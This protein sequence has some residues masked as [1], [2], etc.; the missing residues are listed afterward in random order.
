MTVGESEDVAWRATG[1]DTG[2]RRKCK[3]RLPWTFHC[4]VSDW[5]RWSPPRCPPSGISVCR[6]AQRW[7]LE[8]GRGKGGRVGLPGRVLR[9]RPQ[10]S[11][12]PSPTVSLKSGE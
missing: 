9:I 3:L 8:S 10:G 12:G 2:H 1:G 5:P 4:F 6:K 7:S 11:M